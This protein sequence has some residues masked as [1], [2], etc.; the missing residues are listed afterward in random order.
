[1]WAVPKQG[2]PRSLGLVAVGANGSLTLPLPANATPQNIPLLAI[3]L[4]PKG[5]STNPN[6]P[7]GP[8][9]LKGAWVQI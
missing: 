2:N 8:I 5:G 7:S 3:S 9:L 4:E 6:G 1:L